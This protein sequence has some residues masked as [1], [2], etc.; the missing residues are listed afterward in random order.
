MVP[1]LPS[2]CWSVGK[3]YN[4][5]DV[6]TCD[7]PLGYLLKDYD[8]LAIYHADQRFWQDNQALF[9]ADGLGK[10]TGVYKV[11]RKN[12]GTTLLLPVQ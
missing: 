12:D 3:K 4:E 10:E 7:Q 8:Y 1:F 6:W 9:S 5:A 2:E 11:T